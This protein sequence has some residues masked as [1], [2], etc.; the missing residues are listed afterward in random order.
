MERTKTKGVIGYTSCE[1]GSVKHVLV[2]VT[3]DL[4]WEVPVSIK[5]STRTLEL[6]QSNKTD[7]QER[8]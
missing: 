3:S 2:V 8:D 1:V 6:V 7:F 4:R 5:E